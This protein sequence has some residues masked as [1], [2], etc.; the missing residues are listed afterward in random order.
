MCMHYNNLLTAIDHLVSEQGQTLIC[1]L[2]FSHLDVFSVVVRAYSGH[3]S[4][5][6][7][8]SVFDFHSRIVLRN[9]MWY[10]KVV[11]RALRPG[12][13]PVLVHA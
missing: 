2:H 6:F 1:I 13:S 12:H 11:R 5:S 10:D 9:F 7:I 8:Q 3:I 4:K